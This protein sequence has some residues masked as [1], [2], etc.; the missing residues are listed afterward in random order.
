MKQRFFAIL[1]ALALLLSGCAAQKSE[2]SADILA[3]TA[4][5]AQIVGAITAGTDLTVATLISE[6]VS[7][8]HD[9]ALSVDQMRA[10]EQAM[11]ACG[12]SA[13]YNTHELSRLYRDA[14]AG[15]FQPSDQESLHAAWANLILG[16]I[17]KA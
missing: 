7:C 9:Y 16:P 2:P 10:V 3:T 12:G 14:L 6:P 15:L 11:R 17:E 5:V 4:P 13:Y 1:L 8:V